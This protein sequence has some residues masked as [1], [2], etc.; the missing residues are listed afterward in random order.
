MS[1]EKENEDIEQLK[2]SLAQMTLMNAFK[3]KRTELLEKKYSQSIGVLNDYI[4]QLHK[5]LNMKTSTDSDSIPIDRLMSML[6]KEDV[7]QTDD[8]IIIPKKLI[9]EH[10]LTANTTSEKLPITANEILQ[11]DTMVNSTTTTKR[12]GNKKSKS[13]IT[14]SHC[15]EPGHKRSQCPKILYKD[16]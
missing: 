6:K 14:C 12:Q 15:N 7:L 11:V 3:E 16:I 13:K 8:F 2:K 4:N 9:E 1:K 10:K 5:V